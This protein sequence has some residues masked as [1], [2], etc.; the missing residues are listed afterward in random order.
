MRQKSRFLAI[1]LL[2]IASGYAVAS[3]AA[4]EGRFIS[5]ATEGEWSA[6]KLIGVSIYGPNEESI[7]KVDDVLVD[8][9]GAT[10]GVVIGVGGF[11]G[12]GKKEVAMPFSEVKWSDKPEPPKV[13][14][15]SPDPAA[16]TRPPNTSAPGGMAQP[17]PAPAPTKVVYDYP[18]HGSVSV[19]KDQLK[20]APDF[21]Y[22]SEKR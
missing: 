13:A 16:N 19:T 9:S 14:P 20:A 18:D 22:A 15:I 17:T 4:T 11:L 3:R 5:N 12:M 7:G 8:G 21:H 6:S 2:A 10:K 1:A